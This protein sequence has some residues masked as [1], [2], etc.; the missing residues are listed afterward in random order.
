M[1]VAAVSLSF[2][3]RIWRVAFSGMVPSASWK[4]MEVLVSET[5]RQVAAFWVVGKNLA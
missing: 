3:L 5:S 2:S 4:A 1:V